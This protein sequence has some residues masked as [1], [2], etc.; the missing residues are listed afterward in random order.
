[1]GQLDQGIFTVNLFVDSEIGRLREVLLHAPGPEIE[2]M[3]PDAAKDLLYN[4]I[5]PLP[6]VQSE[7]MMLRNVLSRFSTVYDTKELLTRALSNEGVRIEM[8]RRMTDAFSLS[9]RSE[10]LTILSPSQ[11]SSMFIEGLPSR[12][13]TLEKWLD[14]EEFDIPPIPNLYFSRDG[15]VV[16]LDSLI[17]GA[18]AYEV[19]TMESVLMRAIAYGCSEPSDADIIF[20]GSVERTSGA[21]FEGGDFLFVSS[22]FL[23]IGISE[24]TN[25][26]GVDSVASAIAKKI[27]E[28]V[29]VVA[30]VLPH[31]R[32]TIHLDMVCTFVDRSTILVYPPLVDGR[33]ARELAKLTIDP[34]GRST[35]SHVDNLSSEIERQ[36]GALE[37]IR[38]GGK[39]RLTQEREQWL[40][41]TNVLAV[42]PGVVIGYNCNPHTLEELNSHGFEVITGEEL[43]RSEYDID[44]NT[45]QVIAIPGVELARGGGGVRCMTMPIRR[46]SHER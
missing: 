46:D 3:T 40:S 37:I 11:L 10:E 24:R 19:R 22:R 26:R 14:T 42:A 21:H 29:T 45:R 9:E 1:M 25:A 36:T 43:L 44:D 6:A 20:D 7:H 13:D 4:D 34:T 30:V 33:C 8:I 2:S 28:E 12:R 38:C 17:I 39:V 41:G 31:K 15:A 35:I 5:V 18:M 32:S 23:L 27:G 16:Y